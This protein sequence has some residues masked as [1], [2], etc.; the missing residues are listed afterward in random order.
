[1][2][3]LMDDNSLAPVPPFGVKQGALCW[4]E[5]ADAGNAAC[6]FDCVKVTA[7]NG[8]TIYPVVRAQL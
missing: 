2:Q 6:T 5:S 4:Q 1:M 7:L 3:Q 8:S